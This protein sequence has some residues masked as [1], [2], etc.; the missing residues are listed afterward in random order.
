MRYVVIDQ[1][2][3]ANIKTALLVRDI[4]KHG[5][6]ITLPSHGFHYDTL[7][8]SLLWLFKRLSAADGNVHG[9]VIKWKHFFAL[10]SLR[11]GNPPV[12]SGLP[13]QRPMTRSFDIFFVFTWTNGWVSNREHGDLRRKIEASKIMWYDH[14][15]IHTYINSLSIHCGFV[16]C[17]MATEFGW[18]L[19][20]RRACLLTAPS[21]YLNLCWLIIKC[22]LCHPSESNFTRSSHEVNP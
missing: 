18:T 15:I 5:L 3:N 11:E 7:P 1:H 20:K 19:A 8:Q 13:W 4:A 14:I 22:V 12:P 16:W 10:L 21:H 9:D 17:H 6:N 2:K